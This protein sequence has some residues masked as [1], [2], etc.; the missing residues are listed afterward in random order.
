M[1]T[2]EW[3]LDCGMVIETSRKEKAKGLTA[4]E[5]KNAYEAQQRGYFRYVAVTGSWLDQM[6]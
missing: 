4:H 1:T 3:L 6:G 5:S 2:L